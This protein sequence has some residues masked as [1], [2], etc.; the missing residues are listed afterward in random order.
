MRPQLLIIPGLLLFLF[1][2]IWPIVYSI[3]ISFTN[4]NIRN[5]PPPPPWAPEELRQAR[6][7]PDYVGL[8]NYASIFAGP[9]SAGFLGAVLWTLIFVVLSVPAKVALGTFVGLLMSSDKVLGRSLMRALLIVPWALP[10]ILSVVAWRYVFDPTYGVVNQWLYYLGVSKPPD[11]FV[12]KDYAYAA[13]VVIEAWLAYP[14][15]MTVVIGA[16]A[17][18]PR[19][20]YEAAYIDGA[21]RWTIFS[22]ITLPLIKRPLIYAT[23]MT[24][25]A[26]LQFFLVAYLWNFIQLYD[27][28]VLAYG[29]YWAFGSPFREYGLAAAVLT[30]SALIISVFMI[31]AI[32]LTGLM[33]GM[34]ES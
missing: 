14:F 15:I 16:L 34:Y 31:L 29:F 32:R 24:T 27:R 20:A 13:M 18:V 26:S 7:P 9:A 11:W 25:A 5:F 23:V 17:N 12:N 33:R 19:A 3:Y 2:N 22:R 10:L 1:F 4:A 21:G 6:Q 8:S 30:T 28:F